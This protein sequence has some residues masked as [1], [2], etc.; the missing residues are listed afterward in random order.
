MSDS[1]KFSTCRLVSKEVEHLNNYWDGKFSDFVHNSFKRDIELVNNNRKKNCLQQYGFSF[2][3]V[4]LGAW[5]VLY[6]FNVS[7]LF[8]WL[9][10]FLLGVFCVITGLVNILLDLKVFYERFFK[11]K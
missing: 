9:I 4:C 8:S 1:E 7:G 2:V 10:V 11:R 3:M 6:S 5:F